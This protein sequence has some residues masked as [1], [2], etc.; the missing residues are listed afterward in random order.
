VTVAAAALLPARLRRPLDRLLG[1]PRV[2]PVVAGTVPGLAVMGPVADL[3]TVVLAVTGFGGV[4]LATLPAAVL[5]GWRRGLLVPAATAGGVVVAGLCTARL[6]AGGRW[7]ELALLLLLTAAPT[8]VVAVRRRADRPVALPVAVL[9]LAGAALLALPGRLIP[10][11]AAAASLTGLYVVALA[12]GSGLDTGSRRAT[13][14]AAALVA[15][16]AVLLVHGV[17]SRPL[18]AVHLAVQAA[19]TLGWAWRVGVRD[20]A[21][22][23]AAWRA[24]AAQLVAA[25]WVAAAAAGLAAVEWYSLPAAGGLLLAA[26]R[27]LGSGPSWPAWGP[28]LVVAAVPSAVLAVAAPEGLRPVAAL[29]VAAAVLVAGARTGLRAPLAVG[30]ATALGVAVGFAVRALPW[31]LAT[32]L[33][34]GGLLLALGVRRERRPVAGFGVRLAELR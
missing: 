34:V 17:G 20:P 6:A 4:L 31:P 16:A 27:R 13:A 14:R 33:V 24:G 10:V 9:C 29:A 26:G 12:L 5:T 1:P 3:G 22:G 11:G 7:S 21:L 30:S 18:L 15:L 2:I 25:A 23:T 8:A 28:G 19:A 32:A